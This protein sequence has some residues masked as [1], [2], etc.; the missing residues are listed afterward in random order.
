MWEM[1]SE[2]ARLVHGRLA[3]S[4]S[5]GDQ[6]SFDAELDAIDVAIVSMHEMLMPQLHYQL[7]GPDR[8]KLRAMSFIVMSDRISHEHASHLQH[9]VEIVVITKLTAGMFM[10][11]SDELDTPLDQAL[12]ELSQSLQAATLLRTNGGFNV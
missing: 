8:S 10:T 6:V 11:L 9:R 5:L 1:D 4:T 7:L 12:S 3:E 2:L